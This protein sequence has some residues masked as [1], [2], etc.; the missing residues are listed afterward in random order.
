M[1]GMALAPGRDPTRPGQ[2]RWLC[3][4][5]AIG[6]NPRIS[7]YSLHF[8][9]HICNSYCISKQPEFLKSITQNLS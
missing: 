9:V 3:P 8:I 5:A 4:D 7:Q 6:D 2:A 1:I